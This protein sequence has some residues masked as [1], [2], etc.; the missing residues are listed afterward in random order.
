[1]TPESTPHETA[2]VIQRP[3]R[4]TAMFALPVIAAV[5]APF[6]VGIALGIGAVAYAA[7]GVTG[8]LAERATPAE[9]LR[10]RQ[11]AE[12]QAQPA[13]TAAGP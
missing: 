3:P 13:G 1:M 9:M 4:N 7:A 8:W 10:L 5:V 12:A 6:G 11:R 2:G